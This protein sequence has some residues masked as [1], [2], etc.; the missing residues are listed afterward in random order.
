MEGAGLEAAGF[1]AAVG[2][3]RVLDTFVFCAPQTRRVIC[4]DLFVVGGDCAHHLGVLGRAAACI[5]IVN[6]LP[7]V[8][9]LCGGAELQHLAIE[10]VSLVT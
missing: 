8:G 9:E 3:E 6:S 5:G 1:R 7:G 4:G 10:Y 2:L